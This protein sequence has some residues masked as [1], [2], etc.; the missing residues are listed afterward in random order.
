MAAIRRH[1]FLPLTSFS[2]DKK[3]VRS[4]GHAVRE[5]NDNGA[6]FFLEK[7]YLAIND[8]F[9]H[10]TGHWPMINYA[11]VAKRGEIILDIARRGADNNG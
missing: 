5:G 9:K 1:S 8:L 3:E 7:G 11:L 2:M 6:L 10:C 4:F